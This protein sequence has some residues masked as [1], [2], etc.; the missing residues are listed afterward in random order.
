[1]IALTD[2]DTVAGIAE[3]IGAGTVSGIR[4]IPGIEMS[5]EEHGTHILGYGIDYRG[6]EFLLQLERFKHDRVEGAVRMVENLKR[7]GFAVEWDDVLREATG[8]V[9]ARPHIARAILK[10][11]ENKDILSGVSTSHDFIERFLSNQSPHYVHRAHITCRE[12]IGL[13]HDVDGVAIWSHPAIHFQGD[14]DGL[15][16][17]LKKL[18]GWGIEGIEVFNPSHTEDDVELLQHL[19]ARYRILRTGGSDFHEK[20]GHAPDSRGL[21]AAR[22]VGD[23]ETYGFP[24]EDIIPALDLVMEKRKSATA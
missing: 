14:P 7:A 5:A 2:H 6:E 18:A 4:V 20:G 15:E 19:A 17:F 9:I 23:F 22:T 3:V 24:I 10:H 12:A 21:H 1:M 13:I 16:E 8:A 11:P